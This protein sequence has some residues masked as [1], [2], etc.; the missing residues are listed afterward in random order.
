[1][2]GNCHS[3]E[4][5]LSQFK[6]RDEW[7]KT[8]D[9]MANNGAQGSDEEWTQIQAYL[10]KHFTFILVNKADARELASKLDVAPAVAEAIVRRRTEKGNF[11]SIDDIKRVPGVDPAAI[12]ARK[13]RFLFS[14]GE[15]DDHAQR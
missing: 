2:C 11:T 3:P 1:M 5:A 15:G 12:D 14:T 7:T 4:S 6:T 10:D 9:E 8:L 13:D